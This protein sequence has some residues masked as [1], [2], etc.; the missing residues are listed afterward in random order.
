MMIGISRGAADLSIQIRG[1]CAGLLYEGD[2]SMP[3]GNAGWILDYISHAG[4]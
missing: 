4:R 2:I 3:R 1:C